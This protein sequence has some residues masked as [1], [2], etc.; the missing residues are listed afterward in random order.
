MYIFS[1]PR[2]RIPVRS[3]VLGIA[4]CLALA[5]A[6][7]ATAQPTPSTSPFLAL[8]KYSGGGSTSQLLYFDLAGGSGWLA[9]NLRSGNEIR[10]SR[11]E[12]NLFGI[13]G[14]PADQPAFA[15]EI[16]LMPI[17]DS[18][19]A[20]RS[21]LFV[22]SSTGY[23][24]YLEDLGR[25]DKIGKVTTAIGRPFGPLAAMDG[26]FAL[27]EQRDSTGRTQGAYLYAASKGE[28]LYISGL[29]DFDGEPSMVQVPGL[30][31]LAGPVDSVTLAYEE[32]S[33]AYA[34]LDGGAAK[35]SFLDATG[36]VGRLAVRQGE[37][38]LGTAFA[39]ESRAPALR[40]FVAVPLQ[41]GN[42]TTQ[43]VWILDVASGGIGLL[44]GLFTAEPRVTPMPQ[45]LY[46]QIR[47]S[48]SPR[49]FTA[50]PHGDSGG[51]TRGIWL[52]DNLRGVYYVERPGSPDDLRIFP[53]QI[54]RR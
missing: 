45:N 27:L 19:G 48:E 4:V 20:T 54:D 22:E 17:R 46:G 40:R 5:S 33:R 14:R 32:E 24:A 50:V 28:G 31:Q 12:E 39:A 53:V 36:N 37:V 47:P 25:R 15:G 7:P 34:I 21:A 2:P 49:L 1:S 38:D 52:F 8:P 10:T 35:V 30:P 29:Q 42:D 9:D 6:A 11:L 41:D 3:S 51:A 44:Q 18:G 13:I 23:V 26:N 43:A 16:F